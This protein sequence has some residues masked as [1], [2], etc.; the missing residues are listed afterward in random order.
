MVAM[1]DALSGTTG[2]VPAGLGIRDPE[3]GVASATL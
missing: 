3:H 1:S 2:P